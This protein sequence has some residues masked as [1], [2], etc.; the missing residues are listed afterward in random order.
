M[1]HTSL[2]PIQ[3]QSFVVPYLHNYLFLS[4]ACSFLLLPHTLSPIFV[5]YRHYVPSMPSVPLG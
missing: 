4:S 3:R 5:L 1:G 2:L